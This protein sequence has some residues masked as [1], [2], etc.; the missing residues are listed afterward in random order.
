MPPQGAPPR[1]AL[2]PRC[3]AARSPP[4]PLWAPTPVVAALFY[5]M[6]ARRPKIKTAA[7]EKTVRAQVGGAILQ[8]N[9]CLQIQPVSQKLA[10]RQKMG[11]EDCI[12]EKWLL[13]AGRY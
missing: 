4:P 6:P 1:A 5:L 8:R 9:M 12:R 11:M 7:K 2:A 13:S 3:F 10:S